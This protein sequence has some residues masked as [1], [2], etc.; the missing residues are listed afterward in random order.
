MRDSVVAAGVA[1]ARASATPIARP[2]ALW[3][4]ERR[5]LDALADAR[6]IVASIA[7]PWVFSAAFAAAPI[8]T[9]WH[10]VLHWWRGMP[11]AL[12][13]AWPARIVNLGVV[14]AISFIFFPYLP[15]RW[16]SLARRTWWRFTISTFAMVGAKR[17]KMRSTP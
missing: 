10:V 9:L 6:V 13:V 5:V 8:V 2:S 3:S 15:R 16:W 7:V 17:G 12:T 11:T 1:D 14:H 4:A